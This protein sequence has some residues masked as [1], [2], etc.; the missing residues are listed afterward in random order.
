MSTR[1]IR[2]SVQGYRVPTNELGTNETGR[3][4]QRMR[5]NRPDWATPIIIN[6]QTWIYI[7]T[8]IN[9]SGSVEAE[10]D[11]ILLTQVYRDPTETITLFPGKEYNHVLILEDGGRRH[12][13]LK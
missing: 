4:L 2:Y 6:G 13:F 10:A 3:I 1:R 5:Q 9:W 11:R 12:V 7:D 8:Q